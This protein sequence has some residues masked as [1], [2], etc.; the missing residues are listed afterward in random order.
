ML[1]S[2]LCYLIAVESVG[3]LII[4]GGWSHTLTEIYILLMPK[5]RKRRSPTKLHDAS[6]VSL[7]NRDSKISIHLPISHYMRLT[8]LG[9]E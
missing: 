1:K 6:E 4:Y 8:G 9:K 7:V 5:K 2:V 3:V